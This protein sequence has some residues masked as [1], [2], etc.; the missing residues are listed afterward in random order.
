MRA[1]HGNPGRYIYLPL[2]R[3]CHK[4][5]HGNEA[6]NELQFYSKVTII[7]RHYLSNTPI[8]HRP[9]IPRTAT[10]S[11]IFGFV[12]ESYSVREDLN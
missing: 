2:E 10:N 4:D 9:R 6:E 12:A 1:F 11:K 5:R 3:L 8:P 7:L